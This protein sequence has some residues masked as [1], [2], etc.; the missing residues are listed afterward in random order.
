VFQW[1]LLG[2]DDAGA[3]R[4]PCVARTCTFEGSREE[5][6]YEGNGAPTPS[7]FF[8]D[9]FRRLLEWATVLLDPLLSFASGDTVGAGD[10]RML[11]RICLQLLFIDI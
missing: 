8:C 5:R 6:E 3:E 1:S 7:P 2:G 4:S 9:R 11:Q 10:S